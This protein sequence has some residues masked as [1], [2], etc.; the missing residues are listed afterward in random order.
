MRQTYLDRL[1]LSLFILMVCCVTA[2]AQS[3]RI[4]P[5]DVSETTYERILDLTFPRSVLQQGDAQYVFVLRYEPTWEA[6]SQITI[7]V[8]AERIEVVEY[9]SSDGNIY[10]KLETLLKRTHSLRPVRVARQ[11]RIRRRVV[12]LPLDVAIQIKE[13]F[14][15]DLAISLRRER[16]I[17][18]NPPKTVVVPVDGT[19]YRLWYKGIGDFKYQLSGSGPRSPTPADED[20]LIAWMKSVLKNLDKE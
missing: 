5:V 4:R 9:T 14:F 10:L 8:R 11:I 18:D 16:A 2:S 7:V 19:N 13:R 20:P 3:A 6:E 15:D 17:F 1:N 12:P